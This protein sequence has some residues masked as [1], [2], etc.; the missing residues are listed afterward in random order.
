MR[1][2]QRTMIRLA[3]SRTITDFMHASRLMRPFSSRFVGGG[4]AGQAVAT[5]QEL[6]GEGIAASLFYLGEYVDSEKLVRENVDALLKAIPAMA[7]AGLP[8]HVSVDPTQIGSV[9]SWSLCRENA[10]RLARAVAEVARGGSHPARPALMLDM[11][12]AGV[13]R[14]TLQLYFTLRENDLPAAVTIQSYLHRSLDD[15]RDLAAEGA[16]VRL[17]KGAFAESPAIAH[18]VRSARNASFKAAVDVLFS[19]RARER[20]VYPAL[21]THDHRM[22]DYAGMVAQANGWRR[23][24]WEIEMLYG[25]RPGYQRRLVQQGFRVRLY[26]PF[27]RSWWPYSIRRVGETPRNLAFVLRSMAGAAG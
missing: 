26:L 4:D 1:L 15:L 10:F 14:E 16:F 22:I 19:Q 23:Q 7:A 18:T 8:L 27:G 6:A 24:D 20:G 13:N 2:W 12:D 9:L 3:R 17:V 25:V 21:G 11:E 5:A